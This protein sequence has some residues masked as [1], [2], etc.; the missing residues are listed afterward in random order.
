MLVLEGVGLVGEE[1]GGE[2]HIAEFVVFGF[3]EG[4]KMGR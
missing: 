2:A 3:P 4:F 1:E